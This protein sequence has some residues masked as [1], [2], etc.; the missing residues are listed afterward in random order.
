M[1]NECV[2]FGKWISMQDR[3]PEKGQFFLAFGNGIGQHLD[4]PNLDICM[5]D[6]FDIWVECATELPF[7][8]Q[9]VTH[10][11]PLPPEP[12]NV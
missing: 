2:E 11:M 3:M 12:T 6:G 4:S 7:S 10:W 5:W 1:S 8:E 9:K